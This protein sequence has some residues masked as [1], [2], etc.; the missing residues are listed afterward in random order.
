[1]VVVYKFFYLCFSISK[2]ETFKYNV[3]LF[4]IMEISEEVIK[5]RILYH[6]RRKKVIGGVHTHFDTL[7]RGFPTH[8]GKDINKIAKE[9]IKEGFLITKP[10]SYGLQ[11]SLNKLRIKEIEEIIKRVL[12]IGF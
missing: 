9:L 2:L 6:L 5:A 3:L 8:L 4:L 12:D 7:K 10:T 11:V 1:M